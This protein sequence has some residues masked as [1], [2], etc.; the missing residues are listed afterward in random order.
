MSFH[1]PVD[2][3]RDCLNRLDI[4]KYLLLYFSLVLLG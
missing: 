3:S 4:D 1:A 2:S